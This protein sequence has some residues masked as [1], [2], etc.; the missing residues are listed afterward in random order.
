MNCFGWLPYNYGLLNLLIV[1]GITILCVF[2]FIVVLCLYFS[3]LGIL[4][5][6]VYV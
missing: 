1:I 6:F 5:G 3:G 4:L 2:V